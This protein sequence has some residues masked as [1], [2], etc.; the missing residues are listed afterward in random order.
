LYKVHKGGKISST[1]FQMTF[2]VLGKGGA[3]IA[4]KMS[5]NQTDA[6]A[7]E[8]VIG[9]QADTRVLV[10]IGTG[11]QGR[12]IA[13]ANI[14]NLLS[15]TQPKAFWV[16]L[17]HNM[18]SMGQGHNFGSLTLVPLTQVPTIGSRG[19]LWIGWAGF[20]TQV[21]YT[22]KGATVSCLNVVPSW[23]PTPTPTVPPRPP[24]IN[25]KVSDYVI[26]NA[27]VLSASCS[28]SCGGGTYVVNRNILIEPANGGAPCPELSLTLPCNQQPC[29]PKCN[30]GEWSAWSTC[31]KKCGGGKQT[32]TRSITI[33]ANAPYSSEECPT[34]TTKEQDCN[35]KCCPVDCEVSNFG[36]W[37]QC[38]TSCGGGIQTRSSVVITPPSCG[39]RACP[40]LVEQQPCNTDRCVCQVSDWSEFTPCSAK[41]GG[42]TQTATRTI[43]GTG[44]GCPDPSDT[45]MTQ[46]CNTQACPIDCVVGNWHNVTDC[47]SPC[48]TG[49]QTIQR[50]IIIMNQNGGSP[51]PYLTDSIPCNTQAC[52]PV[53]QADPWSEWS[54]CSKTCGGGTQYQTRTSAVDFYVSGNGGKYKRFGLSMLKADS[55]AFKF[56]VECTSD[57]MVAFL[58]SQSESSSKALEVV[59]GGNNNS[60]SMIRFGTGSDGKVLKSVDGTVCNPQASQKQSFWIALAEGTLSVGNGLDGTSNVIMTA[61]IGDD[62]TASQLY[63]GFSGISTINHYML[64]EDGCQMVH[65]QTRQC[66][67]GCCPID[68]QVTAWSKPSDCDASCGG[69][70]SWSYRSIAVYD[71]CGGLS[72][73][74]LPLRKRYDCNTQSCPYCK[75]SEWTWSDCSESCGPNGVQTGWRTVK[76]I[77]GHPDV[78]CPSKVNDTRTCNTDIICPGLQC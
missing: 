61:S 70:S 7:I 40:Y 28:T 68:C 44:Y 39:G 69:G 21:T 78:P 38:S 10:R 43:T 52:P 62:L 2:E 59:L 45:I 24:P 13:T 15:A 6:N 49:F 46:S 4:F 71:D 14:P 67:T 55:F 54:T 9:D 48:G 37:G 66:N 3:G 34:E 19:W 64:Y 17:D 33:N 73:D 77:G 53:C 1:E 16:Q 57:V 47:S 22:Y 23:K 76:E 56:S 27:T 8:I 18:L 72:C 65:R 42:G 30:V 35:T 51:C 5:K 29:P 75:I 32:S 60:V 41:C 58:P 36:P 63:V 25:C 31:T 74:S 12:V 50:D 20:K 11:S 26:P